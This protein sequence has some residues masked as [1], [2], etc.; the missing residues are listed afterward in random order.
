MSKEMSTALEA[1]AQA[2]EIITRML[3]TIYAPNAISPIRFVANDNQDLTMPD[4]TVFSAASITRG[5]ISSN[6]EGDKE[7]VSLTLS[8]KWE[9]WAAYLAENGK[10]LK[11]CRCIIEDVFMDHLNEGAVW[12][13][14]GVLDDLGMTISE[15]TCKVTRSKVDYDQDGPNI[16]YG[17]T[18]QWAFGSARCKYTGTGGPCDQTLTSCD[19]LGNV[20]NFQGHPSIPNE[21]VIRAT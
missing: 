14:D 18:C 2:S 7:Q 21:M 10:T 5:D 8:N 9:G 20:L 12:R 1:A 6:T 4:G 3:V 19:A 13:F 11:G 17:P 16:D 15:F